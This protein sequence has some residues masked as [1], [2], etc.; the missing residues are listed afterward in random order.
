M[1]D[2][3]DSSSD[4]RVELV[5]PNAAPVLS[6]HKTKANLTKGLGQLLVVEGFKAAVT[7]SSGPNRG[8]HSTPKVGN[9]LIPLPKDVSV[10]T[11]DSIL[12]ID[13]QAIAT[14]KSMVKVPDVVQPLKQG[15]LTSASDLVEVNGQVAIFVD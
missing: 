3:V 14:M 11:G 9:V 6:A 15:V 12:E 1:K 5:P 7:G 4:L 8:E 2:T 13:G 10:E